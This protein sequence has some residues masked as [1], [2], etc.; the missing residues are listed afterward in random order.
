MQ[1]NAIPLAGANIHWNGW[2]SALVGA[3]VAIVSVEVTAPAPVIAV[4]AGERLH[5]GASTTLA[6]AEEIAQDRFTLPVKPPDGVADIVELP[7]FPVAAPRL[8]AILPLLLS[9][10]VIETGTVTITDAAPEAVV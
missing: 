5:V 10:N 2:L 7:V 8:I 4:A 1:P 3:V 6:G 9:A